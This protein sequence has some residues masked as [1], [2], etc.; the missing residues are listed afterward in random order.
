LSRLADFLRIDSDLL[1]IA[2]EA[3]RSHKVESPDR[4]AMAASVASLPAA[5][6]DGLLARIMEGGA[7][8]VGAELCSRFNRQRAVPAVE[9]SRRTVGN[10][11]AAARARAEKRRLEQNRQ[12]ALEKAERERQAALAREKHLDSIADQVPELLRPGWEEWLR[13]AF[14][15]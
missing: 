3:S 2:A 4:A 6:K 8:R 14:R 11:L 9:Q 5:E 12:A 7:A 10:L 13:R 15:P 1:D